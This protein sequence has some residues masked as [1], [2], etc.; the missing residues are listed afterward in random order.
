MPYGTDIKEP[1]NVL[2]IDDDE[3]LGVL[4]AKRLAR[5][6]HIVTAATTGDAGLE[7]LARGGV[8]VVALDHSLNG[9]TGLQVLERLGPRNQRPPVVYV[10]GSADARLALDAI[11]AGADEY[12]IKD[13]SGEFYELL[14]AAIE[15]V[16]ERWR[17]KRQRVEQEQAVRE[18]RDRAELLLKE[19]NHRVANSLGAGRRDG[20][21]AGGRD[22]RSGRVEGAAGNAGAHHGDRARASPP[23]H[24]R[25]DRRGGAQFLSREFRRGTGDVAAGTRAGRIASSSRRRRRP[26]RRTRPFRSA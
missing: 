12:V 10:T 14:I 1:L 11:R 15:H 21:H 2:F 9:E 26:C 25:P 3:A 16:V 18:A 23:L 19:V 8:D 7:I 4:V 24:I 6:G 5:R 17:L 20:A 22:E 13:V